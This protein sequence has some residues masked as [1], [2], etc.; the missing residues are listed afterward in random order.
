[1]TSVTFDC[2]GRKIGSVNPPRRCLVTSSTV[3]AA[4][5]IAAAEFHRVPEGEPPQNGTPRVLYDPR[6][7]CFDAAFDGLEDE[8]EYQVRVSHLL[9]RFFLRE[10]FFQSP[11]LGVRAQRYRRRP[12]LADLERHRAVSG[13]RQRACWH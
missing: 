3:H 6:S 10:F 5:E 1:M 4:V 12:F 8:T 13:G 2:L 11:R 9:A 7:A